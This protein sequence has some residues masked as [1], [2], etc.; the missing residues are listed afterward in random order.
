MLYKNNWYVAEHS[1]RLTDKP[2]RVRMLGCNF[3]L[4]RDAKGAAHCLSDVCIHRGASLASGQCHPEDGSVSCP[5]HGWRFRGDG[6]CVRIP[7]LGP[8]NYDKAPPRGRVD[9]Y[10]VEERYGLI[11]VFLGDLPE[12]ERPPVM[13]VPE[14]S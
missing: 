14:R 8:G 2:L 10:P 5:F 3:V 12:A 4:F 7:S 11:H 13:P 6:K 9:S 1:A